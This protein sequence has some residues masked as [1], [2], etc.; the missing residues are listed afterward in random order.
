MWK[1][2]VSRESHKYK[3]FDEF[4]SISM[5][6]RRNV[7]SAKW[8]STK[9]HGSEQTSMCL[10]WFHYVEGRFSHDMA[11]IILTWLSLGINCSGR[12]INYV[13]YH[14][15]HVTRK[16]VLGVCNQV[17][18]KLAYSAS[19]SSYSL[20]ISDVASLGNLLSR[21]WTTKAL[22]RLRACTCWFAPLLFAY[23]INRFSHMMS[24]LFSDI[25]SCYKN[26]SYDHTL[27]N[28]WLLVHNVIKPSVTMSG[29]LLK[30]VQLL[31]RWNVI[32]IS[33]MMNRIL[34]LWSF[35]M[36]FMKLAKGLFNIFHKKWPLV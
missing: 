10:S 15:S 34:H 22:I 33:H 32:S 12:K 4:R 28:A 19:E 24:M 3:V 9:C 35:H 14:M 13:V 5:K 25:T 27:H 11:H 6:F 18:L 36:K 30:Q 26:K 7:M 21:Q 1:S 23:G 29:F 8:F 20:E 2:P 16:P 31:K 17:R